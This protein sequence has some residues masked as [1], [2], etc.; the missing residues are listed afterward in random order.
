MVVGAKRTADPLGFSPRRNLLLEFTEKAAKKRKY[1]ARSSCAEENVLL[2]SGVRGHNRLTGWRPQ[3]GDRES[4]NRWLQ[5]NSA[6][7]RL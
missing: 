3:R 2:V 6:E 4:N 5:P 7:Q 1:P